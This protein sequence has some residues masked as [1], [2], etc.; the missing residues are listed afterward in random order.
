MLCAVFI[1]FTVRQGVNLVYEDYYDKGVDHTETMK[2]KERSLP[3]KDD[4]N[5]IH[6]DK[7]IVVDFEESFSAKIDSGEIELFRPSDSKKDVAILLEKNSDKITF[8]KA[9]LIAGRYI[10]KIKWYSNGK[11]YELNRP[12]NV[13]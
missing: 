9:N 5:L 4:F 11:K 8:P 12:V 3:F 13:Q 2:I 10:L 6:L 7:Y 1:I